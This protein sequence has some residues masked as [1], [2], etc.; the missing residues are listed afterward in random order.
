MNK[1]AAKTKTN[2]DNKINGKKEAHDEPI[3]EIE[4]EEAEEHEVAEE[5]DPELVKVIAPKKTNKKAS[6]DATDYVP[7]LERGDIEEDFG[8]GPNDF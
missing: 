3:L 1:T 6:V 7:E 4:E 2:K 8:S 5:L